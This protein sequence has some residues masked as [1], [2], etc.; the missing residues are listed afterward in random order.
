MPPCMLAEKFSSFTLLVCPS[1]PS[2]G[3]IVSP[4]RTKYGSF[5]CEPWTP[6]RYHRYLGQGIGGPFSTGTCVSPIP[7]RGIGSGCKA[8]IASTF[9]KYPSKWT[10]I[11]PFE[12]VPPCRS[13]R[14]PRRGNL[15]FRLPW[16][17]RP[18]LRPLPY[19]ARLIH[20]AAETPALITP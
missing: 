4:S 2:P 1:V 17:P 9:S 14:C 16:T 5:C 13:S 7:S 20:Q 19:S 10:E 3:F 12:A 18:L 8:P 15:P 6:S 11:R